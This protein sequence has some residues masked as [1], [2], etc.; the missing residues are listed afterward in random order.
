MVPATDHLPALFAH[1]GQ[2][3]SLGEKEKELLANIVRVRKVLNHQYVLQADTVCQFESF[4]VAGCLRM[5]FIDNSGVEHTLNFAIENWWTSDLES[6]LKGTPSHYH[7]QALEDSIVLQIDKTSLD[8]LYQQAPI[9]ER[10]FRILHQNAYIAQS[11]RILQN[12][13]LSGE[14]RYEAFLNNYPEWHQ[15]IPQKYIASY[16]GITPVF[17]S[18][19][20]KNISMR[21]KN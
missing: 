13:S 18:Q 7:I 6:F 3:I 16:L 5:F 1:I 2:Y 14:Q 17:L 9:F 15:R 12:I 20:R 8:T 4:V 21:R 11:R 10:Y 19:I